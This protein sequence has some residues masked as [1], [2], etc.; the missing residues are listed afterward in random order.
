MYEYF[1]HQADV[2]I[3]GYG[4]NLE[5]AFVEGAKAMFQV[6]CEIKNVKVVKEIKIEVE[7]NDQET[8][9]IEWLNA[10]L[11]QKDIEDMFFSD[12]EVKIDG[13][14][15]KGVAKGE[16]MDLDRHEVKVE[17]KA[18]TYAQ[19]KVEEIDKGYKVQCV[20]DV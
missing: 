6:M 17:V 13:N 18:A 2:G 1:E 14:K 3:I 19:L 4:K 9:F 7:G 12:F 11:S 20:V 10:L 8:M 5:E 16:K 15:L